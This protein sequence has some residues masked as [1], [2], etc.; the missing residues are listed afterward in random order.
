MLTCEQHDT[1]GLGAGAA[2]LAKAN[3]ATSVAISMVEPSTVSDAAASAAL[4]QVA[5]GEFTI[6]GCQPLS[7]DR[8]SQRLHQC[9][10]TAVPDLCS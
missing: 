6:Q 4:T 2:S 3:R 10:D 1:Q 8:V 5:L 7:A 9:C